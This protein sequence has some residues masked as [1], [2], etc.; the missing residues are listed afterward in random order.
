M[1]APWKKS[2]DQSRQLIKNQRHYFANKDPPSQ[3]YG[4]LFFVFF[5]I[6]QLF[7]FFFKFYFI[8]KLYK[9]VLV[10]PN[11]KMNPPQVVFPV[12]MY[13]CESWTIKKAEHRRTD[14]LLNC[15]VGED[16]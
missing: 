14:V 4:F 1:L 2:Y 8:F 12:V 10:L 15:G 6:V 3:G 11:I 16:S 7:L 9:T 13:G 5:F